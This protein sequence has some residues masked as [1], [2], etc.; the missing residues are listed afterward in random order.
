MSRFYLLFTL[1]F[2]VLLAFPSMA[3][4]LEAS[5]T[6]SMISAPTIQS[7]MAD[8]PPG[9]TVTLTGSNWQ[10]GESVHI[11]VNDTYGASWAR[12][13]DVSANANGEITDSFNLPEWFVSDYDVTATGTQSGTVRTTFTDANPSGISVNP[14]S[15]SV[16]QGQSATYDV[17]V[18]MGGSAS[19]C[20]TTLSASGLPTGATASFSGAN[21]RT[22]NTNYTSVL[23]VSTTNATPAGTHTFNVQMTRGADCQGT[24][25]FSQQLTLVVNSA[26]RAPV[27]NAQSI[28]ANEDTAK[29]ITLTGT[30]ADNNN[31]TYSI[32][33]NPSH[34]TLTGSGAN[35]TYT[36]NADYNGSDSFT[37]KVN[38]G[39]TDSSP[40][41]V[42]ITVNAVNDAPSFTKGADQTVNEDSGAHSVNPW[43]SSIS[44][45]PA[46]ESG[47]S[48]DFVI[49]NN[50]NS[51]LFSSG[52]SVSSNGTLS[53]TPDANKSGT[54]TITLKIHD[55]GG[56][57]NGG[58][59]ES[60]TQSFTISVN[61]VNDDPVANDDS[62]TIDE[63]TNAVVNVL[64]NDSDVDGD[65]LDVTSF[66]Q[67]SEGTVT[68]DPDGKLRYVP[69]N[70]FNGTNSFSYTVSD[71]HGG[72][73]S[74]TVTVSVTAV[75]DAPVANDDSR[76]IDED[77]TLNVGA[78]GVLGNDT[79]AEND[80]LHV[81][82]GNASSADGINPVS[83]PSH[84]TLNL[85]S[86]GSFTYTPNANYNG[87]DSFTYK[88]SDSALDSNVATVTITVNAVNDRPT[89]TPDIPNKT[90]LE[91]S[92]T[93]EISFTIG[94]AESAAGDLTVTVSSSDTTLVPNDNLILGG[95]GADRTIKVKPAANRSG[96]PATI[97]LTVSDGSGPG[98]QSATETFDVT[99]TPVNDAPSFD[100]P[101]NAPAVNEDSGAHTVS[102]FASNRDVGPFEA[103]QQITAFEV[104]NNS[105]T[106]LFSAGPSID[107]ATGDLTYTPA[108][109]K[110]GT[111]DITVQAKDDGGTAN[112]GLNTSSQKTF[113]ITV[114]SVNDDPVARDDE[115]NTD[116]DNS[117]T[118]NANDGVLSNDSDIDGD[119]LS[120][121]SFN[122][123]GHGSVTLN[124]DGS[125]TYTPD[126]NYFGDDSFTYTV[127]DGA[128]G[129]ADA[130]VTVHI[131]AV[132]DAPVAKDLTGQDDQVTT[133][134][135]TPKDIT[136]NAS[137]VDSNNLSFSILNLPAH[138]TLSGSGAN[139]TYTPDADYNGPDTF[140]FKVCDDSTPTPLCDEGTVDIVVTPVNDAPVA[141]DDEA[142]T[143]EDETIASIPVLSN[144]T[145][146][147]NDAL[148]VVKVSEA[149]HGTVTL[150]PDN[151]TFNYTPEANYNGTDE[152]TYKANDGALDSNVATVTITVRSVN[153]TPVARDDDYNVDEDGTLT[154]GASE[155]I[156][157]NDTDTDNDSL[158]A[159]LISGPSHGTLDFHGDGSF[160]YTPHADYYGPDS[161][162]YK[163]NDGTESSNVATVT[164][165]VNAVNDKPVGT[166]DTRTTPENTQLLIS[167]ASLTANDTTGAANE[168]GQSLLITEV[169]D[170]QHGSVTLDDL[171][172]EITFTPE[173]GYNGT[174][175]SFLYKLCDNGTPQECATYKVNVNITVT[176]VNDPPVANDDSI[177]VAED[178]EKSFDATSNDSKGPDNE[179]TQTLTV[180]SIVSGPANGTAS[181]NSDGT[182]KYVP[183]AN[184]H[185]P[186]QFDYKV[187][188]N[189]TTNGSSDHKC[190]IGAVRVTVTP[191]NDAPVARDDDYNV[192]E[193]N[194]LNIPA[195]GVLSNDSDIDGDSLSAVLVDG[196]ANGTLNLNPNGS[197]SYTPANNY[198]GPDTLT[199]RANDGTTG[200]N[201]ATVTINVGPVNDKPVANDDTYNVD[202]DTATNLPVLNN[203][204]DAD[205]DSLTASVVGGPSHGTLTPNGNGFSYTPAN[206][207]SGADS[208]TYKANDGTDDSNVA[209]VNITVREVNDNPVISSVTASGTPVDEGSSSNIKVTA[210]DPDSPAAD[211]RYSFDCDNN[212]TFEVGPQAADSA[213]CKFDDGAKTYE[214]NV[215]VS[216][217]AGGTAADSTNVGVRNVAPTITGITATPQ[218]ALLNQ[219][220]NV[221]G[222]ATDPSVADTNADFTWKWSKDG[223]V[224]T[225]MITNILQTSFNTCGPHTVNA[226]ATDKDGGVSPLVTK[227]NVVNVLESTFRPPIDGPATNLTLKG[228]VIPVKIYAGCN[229]IVQPGL[230]PNIKLL[231]GDV[232]AGQEGA[233]DVVEAYSTSSADSTG[234]MRP[235]DGGYIYN[236]QVPGG[237]T[238][239][240]GQEFTIRVYPLA[241]SA[242]PTA[243]PPM[244]AVLKIKK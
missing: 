5:P 233:G 63:D 111:A 204:T 212:G 225:N 220:I 226:T 241:T 158:S 101:A 122:Q 161:F 29:T 99:V 113:T 187:C 77:G 202:E 18:Q 102:N 224:Q 215:R 55:D 115:Y 51:T 152:F 91:D 120:V 153:D 137:D 4:A 71:G 84:G 59:N 1:T 106:S 185:G 184:Y 45:G 3:L 118:V 181:M 16:T 76:S 217:G 159:N 176:E 31:L 132:N 126:P 232:R 24:G 2:V 209:T 218:M 9:A 127:S 234:W 162:T 72:T 109:N 198:N 23:T 7:D 131:H 165:N 199:Y 200:S 33:S 95:S 6:G 100:V 32:V 144:D 180:D 235:V 43:A 22:G 163:A 98:S 145:D 154:K 242:N 123:P 195:P 156:L 190:D 129:S 60:A 130:T 39:T 203:D 61:P 178:G 166:N 35:Q 78:P 177:T 88:A 135:D 15:R 141:V 155:G 236:L 46:N 150:N 92:D 174:E 12:N 80:E 53:Y 57:A 85:N 26:N 216:D 194:P 243:G 79:D 114:N 121:S 192:D 149:A 139:Q 147:E 52:P 54:A 138:G 97:T 173:Q 69:N 49:T 40:A 36:P 128:G 104:T 116:E 70:N 66:T 25:N 13:V 205:G 140:T 183:D 105:D 189:G 170:A 62:A 237:A 238:V 125:F 231:N 168:S 50:S 207:Y 82:D 112:G 28:T 65:S 240:V 164:I 30:D 196:P 179:S 222:T 171:N 228:K 107:P 134:E 103:G 42:S 193:D 213:E 124:D 74:A 244:Y 11:S 221:T 223:I 73:D 58:V 211:L 142:D 148:T 21:P 186:D 83:G 96:G 197:F 38:D 90:I 68:K 182:I 27:A 117:L 94:D 20:T 41:T 191:V 87:P 219:N 239:T 160:S 75:N 86:N 56:T 48:V 151:K 110:H 175:A 19:N 227:S 210:S 47:Q 34:G 206:N 89:I 14:T 172:D 133:P 143:N 188:D 167:A 67:P 8:Y 119:S 208:F 37:F 93:G 230:T 214:V 146:V 201:I 169:S 44:K 10:P 64:A 108:A 157:H 136:L 229:T 17:T 81:A